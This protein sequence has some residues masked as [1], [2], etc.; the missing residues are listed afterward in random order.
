MVMKK[1]ASSVLLLGL[2][3]P[4]AALAGPG[5]DHG[6]ETPVAVSG[7]AP[8]RQANGDV[9]LPKPAQRQ[10]G[11][12]T[13]PVEIKAHSK[14]VQLNGQVV[15][16]PRSGG[17]V[18][19]T[20]GGRFEPAGTGVPQLGD[21]V[22]KGQLLGYVQTSRAPLEQ[23]A[24]QAQLAQ[25]KSEL[26]LAQQRLKRLSQ[27]SETIPGKE[28]DAAKAQVDS[29]SGQVQALSGGLGSREA[30]RAPSA[31]V[32]AFSQALAG[33]VFAAGDV[34]FEIVNPAVVRVEAVWYQADTT[35]EFSAGSI[36]VNDQ[37]LNL[38][39]LAASGSVK[40]QALTLVFEARDVKDLRIPTGQL[41]KV[42]AEVA[43]RREGIA[44]PTR[45][46]VKN[47]SNQSMVWVKKEP[48]LFEP[49]VVLTEALNGAQVLIQ[50]GLAADSLVVVEGANLLNQVR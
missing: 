37:V 44:L 31:G 45:A 19:S 40:N 5:H 8:K 33:K 43:E 2:I 47:A 27:L 30:L 29:L 16:D 49:R 15:M 1:F 32:L 25:L 48:E 6:G 46:V 9:F 4:L 28:L 13:Q 22:K 11:V 17:V 38:K 36:V 10:I 35:P 42:Y 14:T 18:Q 24:Q 34:L 12:R 50:N 41:L 21:A 20:L 3:A 26:T 39:Y 23:S 7:D